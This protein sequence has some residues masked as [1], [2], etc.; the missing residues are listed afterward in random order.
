MKSTS[1]P[2]STDSVFPKSEQ[3]EVYE[4][5]R[6]FSVIGKLTKAV[7][8]FVTRQVASIRIAVRQVDKAR[9]LL[10]ALKRLHKRFGSVGSID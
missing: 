6:Q 4:C 1:G 3:H 9:W 8:P 10:A 2:S 7:T 5:E